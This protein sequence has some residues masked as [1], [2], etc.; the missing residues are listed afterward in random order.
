MADTLD[1]LIGNPGAD[2]GEVIPTQA[3][4]KSGGSST[5]DLILGLPAGARG[6]VRS[7]DLTYDPS[8]TLGFI[9]QAKGSFAATD[10]QWKAHAGKALYPNEPVEVSA[11]RFGKTE[12][13]R[14][15]HRAD[16]GKVYEV[17]PPSGIGR[18]ANIGEGVGPALPA[19]AGGGTGLAALPYTGGIGS[20]PAAGIG[21]YGGE[22]VRQAIGNAI[23]PGPGGY[24]QANALKEG[25]VGAVGQGIG[26]GV[27]RF[28]QRF[29]PPDIADFNPQATQNLLAQA[30]NMGV[31][32]TPAEATN[33]GSLIG[34]Q[35]RLAASPRA[36]N[37]MQRFATERN[38]EVT[39]A[40]DRFLWNVGRPRDAGDLGRQASGIARDAVTDAQTARTA[41][42]APYY[43]QAERQIAS[44]NPGGVVEFIQQAMPT[45]KGSDRAA[46]RFVQ[47]QL[48]RATPEGATDGTIDMSFR[49]LNG[50]KMAID[51]VLE[52][53]ELAAKQGIDRT[54]H[55]TL[56]RARD[57]IVQAIEAAPGAQG[58]GGAPGPYAAGRAMYGMQ[59][60]DYVE[61]VQ[62]V[63]APLLRANPAN[64]SIVRVAQS[65]MDPA[66]R[67]PQLVAQ[68]RSMIEQRNPDV[69]QS[70]V[71]QFLHEHAYDALQEN[72]KGAV[73]N[74]GGNI[75][76]RIG[77]DKMEGVLRSALRPE[78]FRQYQDI[79]D[80]FRATGRALDAN[81][82]TAFKMEAVKAAKDASRG[83]LGKILANIN[84]AQALKNA[85]DFLAERNY[86][87]QAAQVARI[88]AQG[89]ETAIRALRQLRQLSPNDVRRQLVI[90]H[91]IGNAG[92][93]GASY[94]LE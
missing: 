1:L 52:N 71:R 9:D 67:T 58:R 24:S 77:N 27:G 51:A 3:A 35:K 21:A 69:W 23:L 91:L 32:L 87:R 81:S 12:D 17:Q 83:P 20:I 4:P 45:A 53:E 79:V 14:V 5:L 44:V 66:T 93:V 16:D 63:L 13:G 36:A 70:M 41:A 80:V 61:P 48:Q 10:E 94:L 26:V 37:E 43:Q 85:S 7:K 42:V 74:V 68:A 55:A 76:K 40:W 60:R 33:M 30:Q 56:Q 73:T 82:D 22:V 57:M 34:E 31:R 64:S 88:F 28:A 75:A 49:G 92:D 86:E 62:E 78:Q 90:G 15:Y 50:A 25:A 65:V 29:A 2:D 47:S 46:L 54:A 38:Q 84:P 6:G 72:A 11:R 8:R 39:G 18:L 19:V 89:D 59:S